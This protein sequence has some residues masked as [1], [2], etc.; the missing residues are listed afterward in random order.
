LP[1]TNTVHLKKQSDS[2]SNGKTFSAVFSFKNEEESI[3]E[4]VSRMRAVLDAECQKG[5]L[6]AYELIFVNDA[7][8]DTSMEV[9]MELGEGHSDI[10]IINMSR[11]FGL[12]PCMM[13]GLEYSSGDLVVYMDADLQ[14]PPELIP[15]LL[16][17]WRLGKSIDV[18]HTVRNKRLGESQIKLALTRL[19]YR[20]LRRITNINLPIEAGD[21]KLLSRRAVDHLVHLKEKYPYPRGMVCW[22]GFNQTQIEYDRDARNLGKTKRPIWG[23][24]AIGDF[25]NSALISFSPVPLQLASLLGFLGCLIALPIELYVL[26]QKLSGAAVPGLTA[27]MTAILFIGSLQLLAIGVLGLYIHSIHQEVKGRPNYIVAS[28]FGF[29]EG[30]PSTTSERYGIITRVKS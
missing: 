23:L 1:G 3:P 20:I 11:T 7:S 24:L 4:L 6:S 5:I 12:Y 30:E 10:K 25:F 22:I 8:T 27:T 9:L 14:D 26:Q 19:A 18:V 29:D 17:K 13:A 16:E 21:F 2:D 28:L 15:K